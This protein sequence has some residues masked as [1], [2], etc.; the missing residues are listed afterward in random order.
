MRIQAEF[1][2]AECAIWM[3]MLI[4][5]WKMEIYMIEEN[6]TQKCDRH[7]HENESLEKPKTSILY[8]PNYLQSSQKEII[9]NNN[10]AFSCH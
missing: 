10:S 8:A 2:A 6:N 9:I 4:Y 7:L 5:P 1:T 3:E